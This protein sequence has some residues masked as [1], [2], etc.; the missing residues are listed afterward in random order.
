[1]GTSAGRGETTGTQRDA[2][3]GESIIN[4]RDLRAG[5]SFCVTRS[6]QDHNGTKQNE[7]LRK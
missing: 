1:M 6:A 4:T 3:E 5:G 2:E 7:T